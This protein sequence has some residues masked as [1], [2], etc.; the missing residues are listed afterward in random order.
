MTIQD[1]VQELLKEPDKYAVESEEQI[2]VGTKPKI[3]HKKRRIAKKWLKRY[4]V[5]PVYET[6]K[7]KKIDVTLDLIVGFCSEKRLP[8]PEELIGI[9]K[10][11]KD[12]HNIEAYA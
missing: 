4:G 2:L 11:L 10:W 9:V 7:C 8:L 1:I 6:K 5:V 3:T 12:E